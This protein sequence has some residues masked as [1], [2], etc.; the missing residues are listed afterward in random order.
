M[1]VQ[2][3]STRSLVLRLVALFASLIFVQVLMA[4]EVTYF[5]YIQ[6]GDNGPLGATDQVLIA[7][8]TNE[9]PPGGGY[10]VSYGATTNY[11]LTATPSGR[12][13][14]NYL[15][16]DP[17]LPVSPFAYGAHSN[18]TAILSGLSFDTTYF[19]KISGPG[20][21]ASGFTASFHTRKRG[22]VFSFAVEGD[23]GY[24]PVVPNSSPAK[25]VDYEA[26]IAHLIYNAGNIPVQGSLS[27]PP[28]DFVLNTG[29]N[30][31]NQG[32]EGNYRDFFFPVLNNDVD[33]NETGAPIL[34]SLLYF[35]VDGNH[36]LGSTGVSANLLAD[37]SAPR[38]SGNLNGGDALAF[39]NNLYYPLNGPAGF[40]IQN[41]WTGDTSVANAFFFSYLNQSF[42]SPAAI[43]AFRASTSVNT[44]HGAT[45][46]IDHMGN[47]S[48]DYGNAHFLFLDA[49]PHLFN[50]NL[51]GGTVDTVPPPLFTPYPSAL[52]NWVINDLDSS[53]QLWKIAVFHQPA[54]SSGD[55]TLLN[56]Q[57]RAVAK[58]LED[59]GVNIVFNGHE[60]NYQRTL[61]LRATSR[62]AAPASTA[63]G[64]PA[65]FIDQTYDGRNQTV[66]DGVLYI[67]EGAGGN[68]D[69]DGNL[70]PPRGSGL[71]VDQDDSATG[72]ATPV[73]GLTVPQGPASWLDTNLTNREMINFVPNAGIGPKIT[74][75]FKA[76]VFSFGQVLVNGN[77]LT[78][79]QIS[80]PLSN[81][82]SATLGNPAPFGT[83]INGTPLNDPIPDTVLDADTGALL[84]APATGPAVLLDQWTIT[85]PDVTPSVT[86]Q[87]S[88]PPSATAGGA[89]VYTF[90]ITNNGTLAL[91]GTQLRLTLPSAL[92]FA[93][94]PTDSVTLQGSD[95]VFTVGRLA[96]GA[97]QA[98]EIKTRVA[99]NTLVGTVITATGSLTSGTAQPV[100]ANA[101][102]TNI[103][104][105]PGLPF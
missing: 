61:P 80:E 79:Y 55:A 53:K 46:Q 43:A 81:S 7:W 70:A 98:I 1:T 62:T 92:A 51:P 24:F 23:E 65:V 48:F 16:A 11:G 94:L 104:R 35:V 88:A 99:A 76:K 47:Y 74:T 22:S 44:G 18:Y 21:P 15:A 19:Y 9:I 10:Q 38:F 52:A 66:P 5:P 59:H 102:T 4:Q 54:F 86:V 41:T 56:S 49:N 2:P 8:Q 28:I 60:H 96:P 27:R 82:S 105:V 93:G 100:A 71:G 45:R 84:S 33:S 75:K 95:A 36:D 39:Y 85:K 50:G 97:Q 64:T 89:L 20:L 91:N 83:D 87:L 58:I 14:D 77:A 69:F 37:N 73:A 72:T 25:I 17:S 30:I 67:V 34:R 42:T 101:T 3:L 12:V 103:V 6:P 40:D 26:R 31:Y 57:M 32:S 78:L 90:T 29:D 63:S 13:V 68:R